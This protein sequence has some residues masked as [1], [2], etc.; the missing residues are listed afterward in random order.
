MGGVPVRIL[1]LLLIAFVAMSAQQ[2]VASCSTPK[3]PCHS[4]PA[5]TEMSCGAV[6]V[7]KIEPLAA[8]AVAPA[9]V[10]MLPHEAENAPAQE[11]AL[12]PIPPLTVSS[13][14]LRI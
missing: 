12:L 14:V 6:E 3:P 8:P 2:C 7:V 9:S 10:A 4:S 11:A 1:G 13:T 5:K